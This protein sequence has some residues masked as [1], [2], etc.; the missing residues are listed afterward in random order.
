MG[1]ANS[2]SEYKL[3]DTLDSKLVFST[4]GVGV[5]WMMDGSLLEIC[6]DYDTLF[7][8][9]IED[10]MWNSPVGNTKTDKCLKHDFYVEQ[11]KGKKALHR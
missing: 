6:G 11:G 3:G 9:N 10:I 4:D 2:E 7:G 1:G 8:K 5:D